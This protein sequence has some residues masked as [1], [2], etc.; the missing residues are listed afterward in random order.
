MNFGEQACLVRFEMYSVPW[1]FKVFDD[2][3]HQCNKFQT[4]NSVPNRIVRN[5]A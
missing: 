5:F 4:E 2:A 3:E 1:L